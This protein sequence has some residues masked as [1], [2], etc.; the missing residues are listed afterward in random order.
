MKAR[1]VLVKQVLD[2]VSRVAASVSDLKEPAVLPAELPSGMSDLG[3]KN[4]VFRPPINAY[5][6]DQI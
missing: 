3:H 2:D 5:G 1:V 4:P 6:C